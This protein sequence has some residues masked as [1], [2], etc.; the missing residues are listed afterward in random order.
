MTLC[1]A[2]T[3]FI[4]LPIGGAV[5]D[6]IGRKPVL[7][8]IASLALITAYPALRWLVA[9]PSFINLLAVDMLFSFYFGIYNGAMVAALSEIGALARPR[10][11]LLAR[12]QP[13]RGAVRHLHAA[14]L[15]VPDQCERQPGLAGI[16]ADV[17][18]LLQ[19]H[20]DGG[21]LPHE[22]VGCDRARGGT[23]ARRRESGGDGVRPQ[24]SKRGGRTPHSGLR[25]TEGRWRI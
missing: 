15:D 10:V 6:R 4:W 23:D 7:L 2:I 13:R 21:V 19:H 5:S 14:R 12:V 8:T 25:L 11:R 16:L 18:G 9:D 17:R 24:T 20:G 22:R 3:N 1:V